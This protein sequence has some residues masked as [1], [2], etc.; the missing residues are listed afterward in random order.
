MHLFFSGIGGTGIGPLA[1]IAH[2]AGYKVSGSD[3]QSSGYIEYLKNHGI[4]DIHIGQTRENIAQVN[5]SNPIDWFV[6]SSALSIENPNSP[7]LAFVKEQSIKSSKR[8][9]LINFIIN[10]KDLNLVAI[11]GTHGKSTTTAML[12]WL[13]KCAGVDVSYSVGA[14][15]DFGDMGEYSPGSKNFIYEAD[16]FD[17][18]FLSFEPYLSVITGVSWDHHEI[19]PTR[20]DYQDA[21]KEFIGQSKHTIIWQEDQQYLNLVNS[22]S[23]EVENSQNK[24]I[25]KITLD[26]LYNRLDA[27]LAIR[28]AHRLTRIPIDELVGHVNSFPGVQRRMEEIIPDL[29]TDYAHTPE[30]IRGS[31][32]VALEIGDRKK[33]SVVVVYEPLTDRRQHYM[34]KDY[35]DCFSGAKVVYWLPSYLAREDPNQE[36]IKPEEL[37]SNLADPSIALPMNRD[38]KLKEVINNHLKAGDMVVC[39]NGGG[40]DSLDEWLRKNFNSSTR[41]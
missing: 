18:N 35:G 22:P 41:V 29:Y 30:K 32:S 1:L 24:Q 39:M 31:M 16:E 10:E 9:E 8:D 33:Q 11:A 14:K 2:K 21:F 27:W 6:Y 5:D 20:E 19:F 12:I 28:A 38:D 34:M 40:G 37:I 25:T 23:L 3:K 7:E 26:G 15:I 36:V 17:R 4:S 13:M